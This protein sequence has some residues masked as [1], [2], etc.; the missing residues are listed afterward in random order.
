MSKTRMGTDLATT[1]VLDY[2]KLD[3]RAV[4]HMSFGARSPRDS[5][6]TIIGSE[7]EVVIP[8]VLCRVTKF[9]IAKY[10]REGYEGTWSDYEKFEYTFPGHGLNLE[11]DAVARDIRGEPNAASD[12]IL[13]PRRQARGQARLP[14]VH[15]RHFDNL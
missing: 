6:A 14:P 2:D 10:K 12:F 9:S 1:L 5:Y 4:C 13:T 7:G 15:Y 8:D 11:A 3:A